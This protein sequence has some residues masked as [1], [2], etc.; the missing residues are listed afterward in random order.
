MLKTGKEADVFLLER[1][2]DER[3]CLLAAKRY[4]GAEHSQFTRDDGYRAGRGVRKS[5]ERR[6]MAN[7]T[8]LGRELLA[9]QWAFFEWETLVAMHTAGL[10]VPYPVSLDAHELLMEFVGSPDGV[11]A[12]RLAQ[13][14]PDAATLDGLWEQTREVILA[15]A[16]RG[17]AHGD[18]SPFNALLHEGELVVIDWPQ[19]VDVVANPDGFDYLMRDVRTMADWFV[20][21]GLDADG[22][23]LFAEAV[24]L[25]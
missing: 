23:A 7:K 4:R 18:L 9:Q 6:A 8:R 14:R 20:A 22:D 10:P 21:R 15:L 11:A 1:A 24:G 13:T 2:T 12:P 25:L 5:R 16:A 3:S 19:V 17:L